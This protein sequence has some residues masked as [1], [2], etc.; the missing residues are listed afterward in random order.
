MD[1]VVFYISDDDKLSCTYYEVE[2]EFQ[3]ITPI[4][5]DS[6]RLEDIYMDFFKKYDISQ[7]RAT[8]C[9]SGNAITFYDIDYVEMQEL[10][11]EARI[12]RE[13]LEDKNN[14]LNKQDYEEKKLHVVRKNNLGKTLVTVST[15]FLVALTSYV[16]YRMFKDENGKL[17]R[18]GVS[19]IQSMEYVPDLNFKWKPYNEVID[20]SDKGIFTDNS[21]ED[22]LDS[23]DV[24]TSVDTTPVTWEMDNFFP[25]T[26]EN[27]MEEIESL[28]DTSYQEMSYDEDVSSVF[29][30]SA[31]DETDLEKYYVAKAYYGDAINE[32]ATKYGID[33]NLVLAIATHE[34]GIHSETVDVGGGIGLFQIQISGGWNW[35]GQTITAYNFESGN[36]ESVTISLNSVSDVFENI[37]VGCMMIQNVLMKYDYNLA[38]AITAYNYGDNYLQKV[39][40]ECCLN[41]GIPLDELKQID[42]LEWLDY[43]GIISGGDENYLENVCKYIPNGTVLSF[44]KINGDD[45]KIR[46]ENANYYEN[47]HMR[48]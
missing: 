20:I 38:W 34:R 1:K 23:K 42:N 22:V 15:A 47:N 25:T 48:M 3:T 37:R 9:E 10:K 17:V 33:P 27:E 18:E 35:S 2:D 7:V 45:I 41:T 5:L 43:R 11:N 12:Y 39:I 16:G 26:V 6:T 30:I 40:N 46:Y 21:S 44:K 28:D 13:K 31:S 29:R 32:Y 14:E 24:N 36:Y 4:T 8:R 19:E